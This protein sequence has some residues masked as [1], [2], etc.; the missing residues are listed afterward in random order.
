VFERKVMRKKYGPIKNQDGSWRIGT[1]EEIDSLIKHADIV[2]YIKAKR[3]RWTG[4]SVRTAKE[5]TVKSD[6]VET[7]CSKK[8]WQAEVKKGG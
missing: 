6:R 2:R 7:N 4:H 3:I 5:K 8:D 1:T